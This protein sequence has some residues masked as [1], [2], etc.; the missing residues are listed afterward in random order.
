MDKS[1]SFL[2]QCRVQH[3]AKGEI[4]LV[5]DEVPST[6][7]WIKQGVVKTYNLTRQGEEKPISFDIKDELF[8]VAWVFSKLP[9]SQYFYEAFTDCELYCV[10]KQ[11]Y[12][13]FLRKNPNELFQ[14]FD[15]FITRYMNYQMRINALEQSKASSKVL[16]TI[17]LLS[18]RFGKDH[19]ENLVKVQLPLTQQDLANFMGLTRETTSMELKKLQDRGVIFYK[20]QNYSVKTDKLNELL[21][22]DYSQG[23]LL[24]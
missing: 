8:P 6:A 15:H 2:K 24:A 13:D 1:L 11:L 21:D 19:R 18:L 14:V 5:Q 9:Y 16:Y 7:Y 3:F 12:I 20:N 22:E 17:H 10:P 23:R 4:I